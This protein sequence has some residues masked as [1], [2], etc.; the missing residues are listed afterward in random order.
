MPNNTKNSTQSIL[1]WLGIILTLL[2]LIFGDNLWQQFTGKSIFETIDQIVNPSTSTQLSFPKEPLT[3]NGQVINS[4]FETGPQCIALEQTGVGNTIRYD[5]V[6]PN[7][8]VVV[9]DSWKA[10]WPNGQYENDGMLIVQGHWQG[11]VTI[12]S[13][14]YCVVPFAWKDYAIRSRLNAVVRSDRPQYF[15]GSNIP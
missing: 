7:G 2:A 5:M 4:S 14:E 10:F 6:V 1:S 9:W 12:S 13:G 3:I 15:I 8:W 11:T